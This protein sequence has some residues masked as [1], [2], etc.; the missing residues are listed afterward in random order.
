VGLLSGEAKQLERLLRSH[1]LQGSVSLC[2]LLQFLADASADPQGT[3]I[4]EYHIATTVFGRRDDF[5]S[6]SG[7][8]RTSP[9]GPPALQA[10]GILRDRR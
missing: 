5:R 6:P 7:F 9:V 2:K 8:E 10:E 1:T 3:P 4:N